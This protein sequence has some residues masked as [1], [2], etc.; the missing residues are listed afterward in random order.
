MGLIGVTSADKITPH[1]SALTSTGSLI[2]RHPEQ[3]TEGEK[4]DD[5]YGNI[6]WCVLRR[7]S[8]LVHAQ[9]EQ[10]LPK[11]SSAA[12]TYCEGDTGQAM[13]QS[14]SFATPLDPLVQRQGTSDETSDGKQ[15]QEN[16]WSRRRSVE[17][18]GEEIASP[19]RVE[20]PGIST[21][22]AQARVHTQSRRTADA[23]LDPHY[24]GQGDADSLSA[25]PRSHCGMPGRSQLLWIQ[26]STINGGCDRTMPHR[27]E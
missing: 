9:M 16:P 25:S 17:D 12:G 21:L 11:R 20:A 2:T 27:L 4:A 5:R 1:A 14:Q 24:A 7:S 6:S 10:R 3:L 18:S 13:G 22:A 26:I 8:H 19:Q 15:R 23:P